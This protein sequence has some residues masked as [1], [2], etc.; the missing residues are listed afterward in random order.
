LLVEI[1]FL[2]G[3]LALMPGEQLLELIKAVFVLAW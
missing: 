2:L 1:F 3:E